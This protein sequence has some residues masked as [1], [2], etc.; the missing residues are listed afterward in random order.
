MPSP[1]PRPSSDFR[2]TGPIRGV[3]ATSPDEGGIPGGVE[4]VSSATNQFQGMASPKNGYAV[5]TSQRGV[6]ELRIA[7]ISE[8]QR[9][10]DGGQVLAKW[11]SP[12]CSW[13]SPDLGIFVWK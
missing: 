5:A 1:E 7:C 2:P 9:D 6:A 3:L 13:C 12:R 4:R 10:W 8:I 11:S